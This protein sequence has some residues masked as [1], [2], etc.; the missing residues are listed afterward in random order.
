[1]GI[2]AHV[3]LRARELEELLLFKYLRLLEELKVVESRVDSSDLSE[4]DKARLKAILEILEEKV[5]NELREAREEKEGLY[6]STAYT[7]VSAGEAQ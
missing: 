4:E 6:E 5:F 2:D 3:N 7:Y 1:M